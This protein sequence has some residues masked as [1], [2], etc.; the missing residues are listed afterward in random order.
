MARHANEGQAYP[1]H[2]S[3]VQWQGDHPILY[4]A[5]GSHE[6]YTDC[7]IQ[8]RPRTFFFVNDYVVCIPHKTY[9]FTYA[10]TP[11]VDISHTI[12]GCWR[13][14][15]GKAGHG[16]TDP[17]DEADQYETPGPA[18]PLYQQENFRI[19]CRVP[20]GTPKPVAPL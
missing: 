20:P 1:W 9:A 7:G 4:G 6:P 11:L 5:L 13:G 15:L 12:W 19:G 10:A 8:R 17:I 14:H 18:S 3:A 16:L 2:S